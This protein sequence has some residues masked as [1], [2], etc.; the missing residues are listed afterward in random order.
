M[1]KKIVMLLLAS[2]TDQELKE[3]LQEK[4]WSLG[5][6]QCIKEELAAR[7]EGRK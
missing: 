4:H 1:R 7:S 3:M 6:I 2:C 5:M